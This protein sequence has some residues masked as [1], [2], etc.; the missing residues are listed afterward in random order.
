ME[1]FIQFSQTKID[2]DKMDR[3]DTYL[4][5]ECINHLFIQ[6]PTK[7]SLFDKIKQKLFKIL[8]NK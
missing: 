8:V 2:I 4:Y 1:K 3:I 7:L 5:I 6:K